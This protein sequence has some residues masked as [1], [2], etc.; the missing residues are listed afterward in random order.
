MRFFRQAVWLERRS[1]PIRRFL[2][3]LVANWARQRKHFFGTFAVTS[4]ASLGAESTAVISP[5]TT[6]LTYGIID[7]QGDLVVR[8]FADHRVYDG[9]VAAHVLARLEQVLNREILDELREPAV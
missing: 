2:W 6:L 9:A 8:V 3:W 1:W 4:V 5:F 7:P